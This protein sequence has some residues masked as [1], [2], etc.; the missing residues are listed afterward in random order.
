MRLK[1]FGDEIVSMQIESRGIIFDP[2]KWGGDQL[3]TSFVGLCSTESGALLATCQ[4]GSSKNA[5]DATLVVCRSIDQGRTWARC[6]HEFATSIEGCEGS[7]SSGDIIEVAS[8]QLLLIATWFDRSDPARPF[9]DPVTEGILRSKQLKAFSNDEGQS[10]SNW[11]ELD[12]GGIKACSNT[13]PILRW[14][15]GTIGFA[16]ESLKEYC[17]PTPVVQRAW[18]VLSRDGGQ[19]FDA[20]ITVAH[21]PQNQKFYWDQRLCVGSETGDFIGLFWTHNV[22]EK[23]DMPVH[24]C[25]GNL[26]GGDK[27]IPP[28][29]PTCLEGQIAAPLLLAD[30]RCLVFVVDR[31]EPGRLILFR[32]DDRE[33]N[34]SRQLTVHSQIE[35]A[36][37]TQG[38]DKID[39]AQYWEDMGK[40]TF[41][42]PAIVALDGQTVIVAYYAGM[43]NHTLIHWARIRLE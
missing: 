1:P 11:T 33:F 28:P 10:W 37:L 13:G 7:L 26:L 8:G 38:C 18:C 36:E 20:P 21:D 34:W 40:W 17:D 42:H 29:T 27:R 12:L 2:I 24:L 14:A 22:A 9:F 25:Q 30:G 19:T 5:V 6:E 43:P 31:S 35:Y 3:L 23:K 4:L 16:F 41:G 15:D 39:Y 32:S